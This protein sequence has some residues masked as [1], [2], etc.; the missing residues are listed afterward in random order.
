MV[1][2]QKPIFYSLVQQTHTQNQSYRIMKFKCLALFEFLKLYNCVSLLWI[3]CTKSF[4]SKIILNFIC[5]Q[6]N[7][8]KNTVSV[9][10]MKVFFISLYSCPC[11][12]CCCWWNYFCFKI[13]SEMQWTLWNKRLLEVMMFF[14]VITH[15]CIKLGWHTHINQI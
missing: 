15:A 9:N 2:Y 4:V 10:V 5:I 14:G 1:I 8:H 13:A 11:F 7:S 6:C 3:V 12:F